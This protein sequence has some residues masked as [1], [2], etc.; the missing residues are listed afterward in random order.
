MAQTEARKTLEVRH[1]SRLLYRTCLIGGALGCVATVYQ[2]VGL[3]GYLNHPVAIFFLVGAVLGA[4]GY[5]LV[6]FFSV[7]ETTLV[8]RA[9]WQAI[10]CFMIVEVIL[11]LVPPTTRD[12]LTHHLAIPRLYADHGRIFEIPFS[13]PSYYP[14]L[15]DM[16]YVPF[17]Q[18]EWDFVPKLVH[19]WFGFLTG[20][21]LYGYLS[22]RLSAIYGLLGWFFFVSTPIVV[23]LSSQ[24]YVD[25]G[26]TF[27][28]TASLLGILLWKET[29]SQ[30]WL[31]VAGVM[32]GFALATKPNGILFFFLVSLLLL[33]QMSATG[34]I[35]L[36]WPKGV[37]FAVCALAVFAPWLLRNFIWTGNPLFPFFA[38]LFG[39]GGQVGGDS[40]LDILAIR[41]F[42][43]GEDWWQIAALPLRIFFWGRDDQPQRFDG[44]LNPMLLVFL[45]WAFRGKWQEEKRFLFFFALCYLLYAVFLT[46]LRIRY[47][48]PILPPL[49]I[50]LVYAIHN[51]YLR[52]LK[53]WVLVAVVTGLVTMNLIY[54]GLYFERVS[55]VAYVLG[56]ES[57]EQYL[58]RALAEYPVF[59][60]INGNLP[61]SARV[62]LL[63]IGRRS[64]YCRRD[65]FH[66]N[67]EL[68]WFLVQ[69]VKNSHDPQ[70]LEVELKHKRLT[71]LMVRE[72]LLQ[73]F[74]KDNLPEQKLELWQAFAKRNLTGVFHARGYSLYQIHA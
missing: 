74:L 47:V 8:G 42:L 15:L 21:L 41:R 62:Y 20:L 35:R 58:T 63:F 28:S 27:F 52:I 59:Q 26:V 50:L 53:P 54:V 71:H 2:I 45:P 31:V 68:P 3:L 24:A 67:G 5:S 51:I 43:Y 9:S 7:K 17:V 13:L 33:G 10:L 12:E 70:S 37:L 46:D 39:G 34:P 6:V 55:P 72:D 38:N 69:A 19:G 48:L 14:M 64:Y 60:Y 36:W 18:W 40:G 30:R 44:V 4:A 57:R 73:K 61:V 1:F 66:D 11:G 22:L 23:R 32:A 25:L 16:L 56:R 65:Y 29:Q 49:V